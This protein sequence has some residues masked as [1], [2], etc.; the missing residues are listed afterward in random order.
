MLL[1]YHGYWSLH[2]RLKTFFPNY[3]VAAPAWREL[4]V[5]QTAEEKRLL[6]LLERGTGFAFYR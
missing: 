3:A 2:A 6:D 1:S 5:M 4:A